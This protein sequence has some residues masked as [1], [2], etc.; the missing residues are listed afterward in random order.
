MPKYS[1]LGTNITY[2]LVAVDPK[3]TT[4]QKSICTE[5]HLLEVIGKKSPRKIFT[6]RRGSG[7]SAPVREA[8]DFFIKLATGRN[9]PGKFSILK[10]V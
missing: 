8:L 6:W 7:R 1:E 10:T 2:I 4:A 9:C 5:S 3:I